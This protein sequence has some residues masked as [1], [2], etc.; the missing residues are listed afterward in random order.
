MLSM[1]GMHSMQHSRN[2]REHSMRLE[3]IREHSSK[4]CNRCGQRY[5]FNCVLQ[6]EYVGERE[7]AGGLG[8]FPEK[9]SAASR[10]GMLSTFELRTVLFSA[11][12]P[13]ERSTHADSNQLPTQTT[14]SLTA[15]TSAAEATEIQTNRAHTS[16]FAASRGKAYYVQLLVAEVA[17]SACKPDLVDVKCDLRPGKYM[18]CCLRHHE[19]A[20]SKNVITVVAKF[21]T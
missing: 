11:R 8:H 12:T 19:S 14:S 2:T 10:Y 7:G 3:N 1:H 4:L 21:K 18:E 13:T 9:P 20:L 6:W 15:S 5:F 17:A 16:C